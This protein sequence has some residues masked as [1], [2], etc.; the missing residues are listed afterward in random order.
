MASYHD[1][2]L[3]RGDLATT[4][5]F[6][7]LKPPNVAFGPGRSTPT[8]RD[9]RSATGA[10]YAGLCGQVVDGWFRTDVQY[11]SECESIE[12]DTRNST[13]ASSATPPEFRALRAF[14]TLPH[15][16]PESALALARAIGIPTPPTPAGDN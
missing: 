16:L 7:E 10:G 2:L 15:L 11:A 8:D 6:D 3:A 14:R 4:M 5:A 1:M 9:H 12:I 13:R